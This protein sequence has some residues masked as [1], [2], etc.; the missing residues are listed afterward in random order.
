MWLFGWSRCERPNCSSNWHNDTPAEHERC[1]DG[2]RCYASP[3]RRTRV[4]WNEPW[5][6]KRLAKGQPIAATGSPSGKNSLNF[7]AIERQSISSMLIDYHMHTQLT[8]GV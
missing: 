4:D 7:V 2:D 3:Y 8:D 6:K 5:L 1:K